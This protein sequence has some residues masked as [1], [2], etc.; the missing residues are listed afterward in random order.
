[1]TEMGFLYEKQSRRYFI[2]LAVLCAMLPVLAG[3]LGWLQAQETKRSLLW[4]ERAV[5]SSLLEQ[6]VPAE[7]L[8]KAYQN[9]HITKEGTDFL[10]KIGWSERTTASLLPAVSYSVGRYTALLVILSLLLG[11]V[12]MFAGVLFLNRRER[13]YRE[14]AAVIREFADGRFGR[15]LRCDQEGTFY[16]LLAGVDELSMALQAKGEAAFAAKEFLKDAISDISH[17]LKTPLSALTMYVEIMREEPDNP[18]TVRAFSEKSFQALSRM[19][20]LIL[21]LL[22]VMRL[23]TGSITFEKKACKA[24]ALAK[25]ATEELCVRAEAEG[26]RIIL[27]GEPSAEFFCDFQWTAE[28]VSNLVKNALDHTNFG[29][30]IRIFWQESPVMQRIVVSDDGSGIAPEDMPYIFKRFYRSKNA[31]DK[32]GMGLGLALAK[33]VTKGQG[34]VLSVESTPGA[35]SA[36]TISF[37]ADGDKTVS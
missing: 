18:E 12:L 32:N 36:F 25:Q 34:G 26:K 30:T 20:R 11:G 14:A 23:D 27:E 1:M 29:G 28:A 8:A 31:K 7:L 3:F 17:Q 21:M 13:L 5:A 10:N 2:F 16:Q 35:G 15:H 22:K 19:E 24:A 37:P 4:Q 33:A 6:G 9:V